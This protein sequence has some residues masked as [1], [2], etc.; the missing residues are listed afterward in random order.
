MRCELADYLSIE[1]P[2]DAIRVF[3]EP[4]NGATELKI[5]LISS[6]TVVEEGR[7]EV[8]MGELGRT[9]GDFMANPERG[10]G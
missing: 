5:E 1:P 3:S 9:F 2:L 6:T 8:L 4:R 7:L 10:L